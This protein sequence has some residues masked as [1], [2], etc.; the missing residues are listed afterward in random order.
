[1]GNDLVHRRAGGLTGGIDQIAGKDAVGRNH[2]ARVTASVRKAFADKAIAQRRL[3]GLKARRATEAVA[4]KAVA[5][6][7]QS[8]IA[9]TGLNLGKIGG[10]N[11]DLAMIA[12]GHAGLA[13]DRHP[14]HRINGHGQGKAAGQALPTTPTPLPP[15]SS[16]ACA[17]KGRSHSTTGLEAPVLNR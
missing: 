17:A 16:W 1:M 8:L 13:Q 7:H 14:D 12:N 6:D 10:R 2:A 5:P 4:V 9:N 3:K 11:I 15:H